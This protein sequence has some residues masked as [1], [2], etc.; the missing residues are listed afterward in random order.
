VQ[1]K[2]FFLLLITPLFSSSALAA[3]P[4][5]PGSA[6][7]SRVQAQIPA[8]LPAAPPENEIKA[9]PPS[10]AQAPPGAEKIKF[11]FETVTVD[12]MTVYSKKDIVPLYLNMVGREV[13]LTEVYALADK[14]SAKYRNE[15]Y[16]LS[17]V[18]VPPQTIDNGNI[19]LQAVEGFIDRV[20]IQG[21]IKDQTHLAPYAWAIKSSKPLNQ[22]V[23]EKNM[24]LINDLAGFQVRSVLSPSPDVPGASDLTLVAAHK[25]YDVTAAMDNRGTLYMGPLQYS[26][27][28]RLNNIF[29]QRGSISIQLADASN[30][31]PSLE[32]RYAGLGITQAV[33]YEGTTL[34]FSGN[35][36][37]TQPGYL[38]QPL[39]VRGI[40][41]TYNIELM[42]PFIRSRLENLSSTLKL[43]Y[44]NSDRSDNLGLG[45][46][47][48]RMRVLRLSGLYQF[49][50]MHDGSNTLTAEISKGLDILNMKP[51]GSPNMTRADGDPKFC[52]VTAE[53]SRVQ[54]LTE[55]LDLFGSATGQYA[56]DP[57][58]ASEEFG[59][60]G[61]SYGSAYDSSEITG[62]NG[63][64]ARTEL[65]LNNPVAT[66]LQVLQ[67][68]GF[69][70]VGKVWDPQNADPSLRI[71]SLASAGFGL[72][73]LLN[74]V[75]SCSGELAIPLTRKVATENNTKPRLFFSLMAR[76]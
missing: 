40:S 44:L 22:K 24:L 63:L 45:T 55:H 69:Y 15:G 2:Y 10:P 20:I 54:H 38:L 74:D 21:D 32:M 26:T 50:D 43:N 6:E 34:T 1:K 17:Q 5:I 19:R 75:F 51:Q 31:L 30:G 27:G 9:K 41:H 56:A 36:I 28:M 42:H 59:V 64:A 11:V 66:K 16:I 47:E 70:D 76:F 71:A 65:R 29:G 14:L 8:P 68:Y 37:S 35:V 53:A 12:G 48:D 58:L 4:V 13:S 18:I 33:G 73:S 46:T 3:A 72:R 25:A 61:S 57:L 39:D 62:K 7:P 60:G 23:L 67:I 49:S 52:K